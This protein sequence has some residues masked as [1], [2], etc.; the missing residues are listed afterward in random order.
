MN[1]KPERKAL[2]QALME[3]AGG[4]AAVGRLFNPPIT[5]QAVSQW[6]QVPAER[7]VAIEAAT[8]GK[9]TRYELR[10]DIFGGAPDAATQ[11]AA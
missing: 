2:T 5:C 9:V 4:P 8:G 11:E 7:C 3:K 6:V 10:P 1:T